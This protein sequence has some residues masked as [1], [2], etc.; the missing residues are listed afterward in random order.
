MCRR[1]LLDDVGRN[2]LLE[3]ALHLLQPVARHGEQP[4]EP[5][6]AVR[7]HRGQRDGQAERRGHQPERRLGGH[8]RSMAS[9]TVAFA[10]EA[11]PIA[12]RIA[13]GPIAAASCAVFFWIGPIW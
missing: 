11:M 9:R 2:E 13:A 8:S 12:S 4:L 10:S 5:V 6:R 3:L 7:E 1:H